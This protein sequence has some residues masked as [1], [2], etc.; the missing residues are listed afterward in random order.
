MTQ[1]W[2]TE[3]VKVHVLDIQITGET[4]TMD[5]MIETQLQE[6]R[7]GRACRSF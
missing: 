1:K 4:K 7:R 3:P 5:T 6:V 2:A